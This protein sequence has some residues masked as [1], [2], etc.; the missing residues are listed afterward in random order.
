VLITGETGTGKELLA[1]AIHF[2]SP[3][4]ERP[5]GIIN[6]AAI[7]RELLESELFGHVRGSF[8]GAVAHKKGKVE[9]TDG[10]TLFLDEIGEM[11]L[12]LQVRLL[13]LVQEREIEKIGRSWVAVRADSGTDQSGLPRGTGCHNL[14]SRPR[15]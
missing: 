12:E 11:P 9:I 6:C 13:R 10:G 7:P 1:K 15:G 3:R 2:N 5:F 14:Q 4:R 8:T